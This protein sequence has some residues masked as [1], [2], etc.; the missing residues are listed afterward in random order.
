MIIYTS[1]KL[2]DINDLWGKSSFCRELGIKIA[3]SLRNINRLLSQ[4]K[5]TAG[6]E[7]YGYG[8]HAIKAIRF[9]CFETY[10]LLKTDL[11]RKKGIK[12]KKTVITAIACCLMVLT[13]A[14]CK[15]SISDFSAPDTCETGT[16]MTLNLNGFAE[17]IGDNASEHGIVLQIPNDWTVL[18]GN[19]VLSGVRVQLAENPL[20]ETL[21][22][23]EPGY[24]IW[25]GTGYES[26]SGDKT[27][28]ASIKILVNDFTGN[29]GD[30][31]MF[32][33]KAA[34]GVFR[35]DTWRTDDPDGIFDFT[36]IIEDKFIED[37]LVKKAVAD[38]I[39]PD[40]IQTLTNDT[41][42]CNNSVSLSWF[43]YDETMQGDVTQYHIYKD[44][45]LFDNVSGMTP[46]ATLPLGTSSYTVSGLKP[47]TEYFFA[48]TSVDEIG[49]ENK[50]VT[51]LSVIP[52]SGGGISG[53]VRD[54]STLLPIEGVWVAAY[55]YVTGDW[56]GGGSTQEDGRYTII[57]L[58]AG[59]YRIS[60]SASGD[61][62][63]E[64]YDN[65]TNLLEADPVVVNPPS[66]T[67]S[68]DFDLLSKCF[69]DFDQDG[70]VDG[71]DLAIFA[72]SFGR[73]DC[74]DA[75]QPLDAKNGEE[76]AFEELQLSL[77][78]L[79]GENSIKNVHLL[80]M[81]VNRLK[82]ELAVKDRIIKSFLAK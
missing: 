26:G 8:S 25:V 73:T 74:S 11:I 67:T 12:M 37:I 51:P 4:L 44:T 18:S 75:S 76:T 16:V 57:G 22:T 69:G 66:I 36:S 10:D 28:S 58:C 40:K 82:S 32:T 42:L 72:Q 41:Y 61:Y 49:N 33:I 71:L 79:D 65:K 52:E 70:S 60:I 34:V 59:S 81:E 13:L 9:F 31:K 1:A 64:Y 43:G 27:I 23:P 20:Y 21:Y 46:I 68:I 56:R 7:S 55:D 39:A 24:K 62:G 15:V 5:C 47:G 30:E 54:A 53:K 63:S 3:S 50:S 35:D 45:A 19:T 6:M 48:V 2:F 17:D 29:A 77:D 14:A 78:N 38:N 80:M